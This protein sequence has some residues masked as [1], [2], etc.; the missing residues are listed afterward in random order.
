[1]ANVV[2]VE[3]DPMIRKLVDAVLR[4]SGHTLQF[5]TNGVEGLA[6]IERARPDI[7]FTDVSMPVMDG[8][9]L[10]DAIRARPELADV[11][12]VFVTA[13]MQREQI[14]RYTGRGATFIAKPF[15]TAELRAHIERL[16]VV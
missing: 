13:S 15:S 5:A 10:A 9:E 14:D 4:S 12:I 6:L 16:V 11:R 1:M 8:L 2:W 7:V 3:D